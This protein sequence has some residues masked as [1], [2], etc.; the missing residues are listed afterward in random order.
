MAISQWGTSGNNYLESNHEAIPMVVY[1]PSPKIW[2]IFGQRVL[3]K[4]KH[5]SHLHPVNNY[6]FG[7]KLC[8]SIEPHSYRNGLKHL[9]QGVETF[10]SQYQSPDILLIWT[11]I[12][13]H[14]QTDTGILTFV[15]LFLPSTKC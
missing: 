15:P 12:G 9:F 7:C 11:S 2:D 6:H 4:L 14:C 8:T 1:H 5:L 10:W 3:S 13:R